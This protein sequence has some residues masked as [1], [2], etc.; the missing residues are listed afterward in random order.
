[1]DRGYPNLL[2]DSAIERAQQIPRKVALKRVNRQKKTNGPIF[3]HTYDPR[4]PPMA[5]IQARHWRT[6]VHRNSYLSEVYQ[7]TTNS[8]LK[9]AQY[10][11]LSYKGKTATK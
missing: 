6:M 1:M 3:A 8:P 4:L 11:K 9:A 5:Q 2:L 7:T 10:K